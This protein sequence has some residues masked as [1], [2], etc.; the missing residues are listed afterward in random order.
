MSQA[1]MR[2]V[3]QVKHERHLAVVSGDPVEAFGDDRRCTAEGCN[4]KLSRYN[5]S[6]TCSLHAGWTD[7]QGRRRD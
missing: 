2:Q 4:A 3:P 5:P 6:T 1:R 7:P